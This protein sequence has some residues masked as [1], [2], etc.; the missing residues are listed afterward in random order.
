MRTRD[1][2]GMFEL[3][4]ETNPNNRGGGSV[5]DDLLDQVD[6]GK[7]TFTELPHDAE[8][9]LIDPHVATSINGVVQ[10]I[11]P[12]KCAAHPA[13]RLLLVAVHVNEMK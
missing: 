9:V 12:G 3:L 8:S 11:Q 7:A 1:M 5:G 2:R 13:L 6:I 10:C 4:S